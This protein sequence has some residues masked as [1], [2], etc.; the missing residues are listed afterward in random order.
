MF[1]MST[2]L[3]IAGVLFLMALPSFISAPLARIAVLTIAYAGSFILAAAFVRKFLSTQSEKRAQDKSQHIVEVDCLITFIITYL[4]N[5]KQILPVLA[6]QLKEVTNQTE[7]AAI[8]IGE[9]FMNIVDRARNQSLKASDAFSAFGG[10]GGND[11]LLMLSKET[12]SKVIASLE[13]VATISGKT[14]KDLM[15]VAE[16]MENI[17]KSVEDIEYV[18]N[19]TNLLALNAAIEA[20]R[21]G[22]AGRGFSVVADEV[23]K[24]SERSNNAAVRVRQLLVKIETDLTVLSDTAAR[25]A[26]ESAADSSKARSA[27]GTTLAKID[28]VM[29]ETKGRLDELMKETE[30]LT[31][32]I[33]GIIVS[34]QFQDI[35][36]QRIEHVIQPLTIFQQEFESMTEQLRAADKRIHEGQ[37]E[38]ILELEK[39]Y[40][41]ESERKV[42]RKTLMTAQ[43]SQ[44]R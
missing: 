24:L 2:G 36:R 8:D 42:M 9:K 39:F 29:Q 13:R 32:D 40:T 38:A 30:L 21:A 43:D 5:K 34:M 6:N 16:D 33:N 27:V 15:I 22:E 26:G 4:Q 25:N 7:T 44:R 35:T 18:A 17:K 28:A 41:M 12:L 19:Q 31:K 3:K 11:T 23:K 10:S 20:A 1:S 14:Q 37:N